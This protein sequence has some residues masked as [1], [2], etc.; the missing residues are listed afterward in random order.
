MNALVDLSGEEWLPFR[1]YMISNKGRVFSNRKQML[2]C[3]KEDVP[4][5]HPDGT[6]R[7]RIIC[8]CDD[9]RR[10]CRTV[11][12]I[13]MR[14]FGPPNPNPEYFDCIDHISWDYHEDS[15]ENLRWLPK[16]Q[17]S[18]WSKKTKGYSF[19]NISAKYQAQIRTPVKRISLGLH[20]TPE[21]AEAVYFAA[22]DRAMELCLG[23]LVI[24]TP[25]SVVSYVK[26]GAW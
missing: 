11:S 26:T 13:V 19:H 2:V 9:G 17:N 23:D 14:L 10:T 21:E 25:E 3:R 6:P 12:K 8:W 7:Y 22:R 24:R 16:F 5:K 15:I 20:N 1:N 4:Y 18:L